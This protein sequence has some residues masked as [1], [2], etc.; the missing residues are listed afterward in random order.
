[1][2]VK[3]TVQPFGEWEG[4][5]VNKYTITQVA[6]IQVSVINYG[7]T[8]TSIVVPDKTGSPA[9]VVLGFDTL[10]GYKIGRAHV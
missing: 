2:A 5:T 8:V 6:G 7:A 3:T 9:D 4:M 1:M 10:E